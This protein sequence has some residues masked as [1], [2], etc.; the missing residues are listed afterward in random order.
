MSLLRSIETR[1]ATLVEGTFGKVF[2]SGVQPVELARRLTG[3]MDDHQRAT[4]HQVFVPNTYEVYLSTPDHERFSEVESALATELSEYLAEHARRRGYALAS[5]PRVKIIA[6]SDL[7]LGSF[8][9]LAKTDTGSASAPAIGGAA[10]PVIAE[11]ASPDLTPPTPVEATSI[12]PPPDPEPIEL[13]VEGK[14][15]RVDL[16]TEKL[17]LGRGKA[18]DVVLQ[19]SSVSRA[20][21]E[22]LRRGASFVIRDLGS[23]NGVMVNGSKV[24]ESK[25][26]PGDQVLLGS[27]PITVHGAS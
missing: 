16:T 14:R 25:I 7:D 10:V 4:M 27:A 21:A 15:V 11:A 19:D 1:I 13:A 9:I 20:H 2:R 26:L 5:R 17:S 18:N 23:T 6:D 8:G 12:A 24:V 3:E 22:V